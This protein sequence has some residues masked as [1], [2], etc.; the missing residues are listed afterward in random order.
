MLYRGGCNEQVK[1]FQRCPR[2]H[3]AKV[4]PCRRWTAFWQYSGQCQLR[5]TALIATAVESYEPWSRRLFSLL[6]PNGSS[7]S[8]GPN[9]SGRSLFQAN[10][11]TRERAWFSCLVGDLQQ[12][13]HSTESFINPAYDANLNLKSTTFKTVKSPLVTIFQHPYDSFTTCLSTAWR[14]TTPC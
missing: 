11:L 9:G 6:T 8:L 4:A 2:R 3:Q 13:S 12:R 7:A 14:R 5:R 10:K 1:D